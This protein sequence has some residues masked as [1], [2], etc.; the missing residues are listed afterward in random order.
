[1]AKNLFA[2]ICDESDHQLAEQ[3]QEA[4]ESAYEC[5]EGV[6]LVATD[7]VAD[8]VIKRLGIGSENARLGVVIALK[9]NVG[10]FWDPAAWEWFRTQQKG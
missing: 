1:M 7:T 10:G 2:V 6:L 5:R 8:A 9:G 4:Y 3:V